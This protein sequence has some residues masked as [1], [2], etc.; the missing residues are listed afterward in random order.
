MATGASTSPWPFWL[1]AFC[2][3][4]SAVLASAL[5]VLVVGVLSLMASGECLAMV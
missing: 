3:A 5:A 2:L 1:L 4:A